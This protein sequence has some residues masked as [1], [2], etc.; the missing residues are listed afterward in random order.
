MQNPKYRGVPKVT[1][2]LFY[3]SPISFQPS[4]CLQ[5][6]T[7]NSLIFAY[8]GSMSFHFPVVHYLT[9]DT[10]PMCTTL[11]VIHVFLT[12][13]AAVGLLLPP[14]LKSPNLLS[15]PLCN[16]R[17]RTQH[18]Y[19]SDSTDALE[20]DI[21]CNGFTCTKYRLQY[22]SHNCSICTCV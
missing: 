14:L 15:R 10:T 3:F 22:C 11:H 17:E 1:V 18:T 8:F 7:F 9:L 19:K 5:P 20:S 21:A 2:C 6:S 16:A 4:S 13:H 12:N